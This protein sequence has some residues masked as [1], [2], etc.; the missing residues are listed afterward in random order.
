MRLFG[1]FFLSFNKSSAVLTV[2]SAARSRRTWLPS[3]RIC[4]HVLSSGSRVIALTVFRSGSVIGFMHETALLLPFS[5]QH[6][7]KPDNVNAS[8]FG[9]AV[10]LLCLRTAKRK[11]LKIDPQRFSYLQIT[12][13][14]IAENDNQTVSLNTHILEGKNSNSNH[15][16][17]SW[18]ALSLER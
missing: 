12:F 17:I 11:W 3:G 9:H 13:Q 4:F 7:G 2:S 16:I 5:R 15:V 8:Q 6:N 18:D 1:V 10:G 14:I